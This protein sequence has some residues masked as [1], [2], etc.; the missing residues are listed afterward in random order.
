MSQNNSLIFR[1]AETTE[2]FQ[3]IFDLQNR[4]LVTSL[5]ESDLKDGFLSASPA[6]GELQSM[7]D[8]ICIMTCFS[9]M[10]LCGYH[11]ATTPEFNK[12]SALLAAMMRQFSQIAYKGKNIS[13]Y[14]CFIAGPT[15]IEKRYRGQGIYPRLI[16]ALFDFL[17]NTLNPARLRISFASKSNPRSLNAQKKIG[18][19]IIGEFQFNANEFFILCLDLEENQ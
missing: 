5:S 9:G 16:A 15:C 4:N 12:N 2:D 7:N 8:N 6:L 10:D 19:E 18:C 14:D 17:G 1:R 13:E 11:V 3:K